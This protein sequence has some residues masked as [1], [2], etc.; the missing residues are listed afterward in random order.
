MSSEFNYDLVNDALRRAG[1][2][3]DAAQAH[4]LLSSKLAVG[5]IVGGQ[6]WLQQVQEGVDPRNALGKESA[7]ML[8]GLIQSTYTA[9]AERQSAF[10][11]MLPDDEE[12][13]GVR[14]EGL[15]HWC[16]GYLHGLVSAE[17]GDALRKRL[18]EEP[19]AD[20]IRDMLE[21][22]RAGDDEEADEE[23][24]EAAYVE[25]VEYLRVAAQ[26]VYEE[27]AGLRP[28]TKHEA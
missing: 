28:D 7:E 1:S 14:I 17:H 22:T 12:P 2:S 26:L 3:W 10:A 15:A 27:L 6:Q 13:T 4:G 19:I 9:L 20:I 23:S 11:P 5:G 25:I 18:A 8:S 24:E 16:E 21:I